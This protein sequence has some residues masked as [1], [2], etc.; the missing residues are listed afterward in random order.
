[1]TRSHPIAFAVLGNRTAQLGVLSVLNVILVLT[2]LGA[3]L[4]VLYGFVIGNAIMRPIE[5]IE[6]GVLAVINGRTDLRLE[7][8]S[9]ELGGLAF[10]INQLLNVFTGTEE[11]T[12]DEQGR[13]SMAPSPTT[14]VTLRL[15]M[16]RP[17][18][19]GAKPAAAR[20]Q[21]RRTAR[22]PAA[23]A[24]LAAEDEAAYAAASIRNT[25]PPSRRSARTSRTSRRTAFTN[26]CPGA[27]RHWPRST[28]AA[29]S[30]S[31]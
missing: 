17:A 1:M 27:R 12:E 2:G 8:Q 3:V 7:T 25:S 29:W 10:R 13:V 19:A 11:Q 26:V 20:G 14:G 4:V 23:R 6:E 5:A 9:A 18:A 28:V 16:L 30:A 15:A 31:R 24:K 22:R 21:S